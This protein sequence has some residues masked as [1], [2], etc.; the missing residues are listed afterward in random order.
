MKIL[1]ALLLALML[2]G[3]IQ[4]KREPEEINEQLTLN[5][6]IAV[7]K[8]KD[9]WKAQV[10][11]TLPNPC[12]KMEFIGKE[13]GDGKIILKFKHTLPRLNEACIQVI[14]TYNE[15]VEL[16]ELSEGRHQ[17]IVELNSTEVKS[18]EIII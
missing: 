5:P 14:R 10:T 17:V 4:E 8:D 13:I 16:G 1:I 11:F 9:L 12:H 15:T 18:M 7:F 6:Q 3:C 2:L